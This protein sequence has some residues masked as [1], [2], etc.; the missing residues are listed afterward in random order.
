MANECYFAVVRG[1]QKAK[2]TF[3]ISLDSLAGQKQKKVRLAKGVAKVKIDKQQKI[4]KIG[5]QMLKQVKKDMTEV[6]Q[7]N[8]IVMTYNSSKMKG[9]NPD[10]IAHRLN[11]GK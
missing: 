2:E 1:K 8:Y 10:M 9:V 11:V 7:N 4:A 6:L 3:I 5:T